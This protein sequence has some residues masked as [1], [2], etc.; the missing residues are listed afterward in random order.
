MRTALPHLARSHPPAGV[1]RVPAS[2]LLRGAA[3]ASLL[4]FA[5]TSVRAAEPPEEKLDYNFHIRPILADRCFKC[6][7]PDD[8]ARKAKLRLDK[9]DGALGRGVL[10]P[11]KPDESELV[12]RITATDDDRMP[13]ARS[14]LR[15]TQ[16]EIE[17]LRRWV[18]QGA[19]YKPHWAF[20]PVPDH[21]SVPDMRTPQTGLR[22]PIDGFV[23]ARLEREKLNPSPPASKEDWIRRVSFD[24]TGLPPTPEEVDDFLADDS[25]QAFEKVA[26]RLLKSPRFGERM[27][28]EWLDAARYA[29]S[30]GYQAD[31][32]SNVWPWRDWVIGAFNDNLPYDQFITWQIAGDL[33]PNP[34]REQRLATAFCRL[35][36]MTNE[37]GSIPEEFRIEYVADRVQ[38]V[39]TAVLGLTMECARCHDHKFDP[40]TQKDYYSLGAFFN[41]I[42]EWGTY[43]SAPFRPTPTLPLPTADQEKA[44]AT[45]GKRVKELEANF[46]QLRQQREAAFRDWLGKS[47]SNPE[48]PGLVGHYPLDKPQ[49]GGVLENKA[50]VAKP[51]NTSG[52]NLF[53]PGK[54]GEA[55]KFTGDDAA[56]FPGILGNVD[57]SQPFTASFWLWTPQVMKSGFIFHRQAGTD[58][59]F[60]GAELSFDDGRLLF[61]LVR[62]WPGDAAAVRTKAPLAANEWTH[63][64]V[65]HDGSGKAADMR[66]YVN[67]KPAELEVVRDHLTKDLQVGLGHGGGG[68]GLS[69][70]ERFRSTGLKDCLLDEVRLYDRALTSIEVAQLFDEKAL[71]EALAKQEAAVLEDYYFAA[72]DAEVRKAREALRQARQQLFATQTGI[73]DIMTMEETPEA[74]PA[75]ILRRG[76]YDAPQDRPVGRDTPAALPAW[77]NHAPRNRLGLAKWLNDPHHPLTARVAVNRFWQVF[78]GRGLVATTENF[79]T[80]GALPSHPDLLDWLARDFISSGWDN[81]ALCRK[82][83]LSGTYRQRSAASRE[84]RERDPD[85]LLLAR[86]PS[87][88]LSAEMVRDSALFAGG[89]LVEKIGGTPVKPYQ[90]LG[91]WHAQNAFLPEYVADKGEGLYRRSLYSF[92]RRTSPPPNM[93]TFDAPSREVC[94]ARRQTTSTPLQPLVLLNDPQFVEAARGLGERMLRAE[95][96]TIEER[97]ILGFRLAA[98][99]KPTERELELLRSL[100][101]GQLVRFRSDPTSAQKYLAIGERAPAK[102]LDSADLAAATATANAILNLDAAVMIR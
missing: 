27:A 64:A 89:L 42:D 6:H 49:K 97:L 4:A 25:P 16:V 32:D 34:T 60:H 3:F 59:G 102:D 19:E 81:K 69:F 94:I 48:I 9:R 98:T 52:A 30:F 87:R 56:N 7:G 40:L 43:D 70:G 36:R 31:G 80:Q 96:K 10:V 51:G 14:N 90:P 78:F 54:F 17:L 21:V 92:W 86:G 39:S 46:V 61:G 79:G 67:G 29:D 66:I 84:L 72:V 24:L 88:R 35:H 26:D 71:T 45:Q 53:V 100:Y 15:L 47:H 33:L 99:R 83:V 12:R 11:G 93:L 101:R 20:L 41:S 74:R 50:A 68:S 73:F 58:T 44:L 76:E 75:Y 55:L 1:Q 62:F 5:A 18:A 65:S 63:I 82:I 22:N 8:K 2:L 57:R 38:T 95:G 91:L 37:G 23:V 77:P 13:P 28:L 85:N